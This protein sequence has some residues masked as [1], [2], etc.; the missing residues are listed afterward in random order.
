MNETIKHILDN[1]PGL[2]N[3]ILTGVFLPLG[4]LWLTNRNHR[5][6]KR[7]EKNLDLQY[8]TKDDIREQEKRVYGI[9]D[10][11]KRFD[12]SVRK[13]HDEIADNMLYLSSD[14]INLIY[15]F[16]N[17]IGQLKYNCKSLTNEKNMKWLMLWFIIHLNIS[18]IH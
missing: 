12:L 6:L 13:C 3:I 17:S 5:Q 16:Y 14:A 18:L 10:A 2:I 9:I 11:L 15:K 8:K 1:N 4:I 7:I